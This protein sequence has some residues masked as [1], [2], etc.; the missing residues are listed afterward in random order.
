MIK[1][2]LFG[3]P[4]CQNGTEWHLF[5]IT[6]PSCFFFQSS[7][8][9]V[10]GPHPLS[11]DHPLKTAAAPFRQLIFGSGYSRCHA[12][13]YHSDYGN[14]NQFWKNSALSCFQPDAG[15][16]FPDKRC[17]MTD[18]SIQ[19]WTNDPGFRT[20]TIRTFELKCPCPVQGN[21]ILYTPFRRVPA[22]P[23]WRGT[24]DRGEKHQA[25][26]AAA[27]FPYRR[28]WQITE[29]RQKRFPGFPD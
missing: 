21:P 18:F 26:I 20:P 10:Q 12:V 5:S 4:R 24:Q 17:R 28:F 14:A 27:F 8:E 1:T 11:N 9:T 29:Y 13:I 3:T 19:K 25:I 22:S 23:C 16:S 6:G 2:A 7:T 15:V